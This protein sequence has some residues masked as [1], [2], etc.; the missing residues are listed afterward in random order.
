MNVIHI[1]KINHPNRKEECIRSFT[2]KLDSSIFPT[3]AFLAGDGKLIRALK[4]ILLMRGMNEEDI[5]METFFN[6]I[7]RSE[8]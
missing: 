7:G 5:G 6:S 8:N 2:E 3:N 4:D 1:P